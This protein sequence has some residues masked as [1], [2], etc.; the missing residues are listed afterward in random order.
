MFFFNTCNHHPQHKFPNSCLKRKMSS[1]YIAQPAIVWFKPVMRL[2]GFGWWG[3]LNFKEVGVF[4]PE[5]F[6]HLKHAD[7]VSKIII[8]IKIIMKDLIFQD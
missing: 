1:N 8:I 7:A 6:L 3:R 5:T 4:S 2:G